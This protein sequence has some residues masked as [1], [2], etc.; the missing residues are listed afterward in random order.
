[1]IMKSIKGFFSTLVQVGLIFSFCVALLV[2]ALT[3]AQSYEAEVFPV[4]EGFQVY[5]SD[6]N[7]TTGN[8]II[9]GAMKKVRKCEFLELSVFAK[10]DDERVMT[11]LKVEFLDVGA[12]SR[13][14]IYQSFGPWIIDAAGFDYDGVRLEFYTRHRCHALWETES[15]LYTEYT[16]WEH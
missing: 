3:I 15:H 5:S 2:G 8:V 13:P 16:K 10:F 1:M 4:V 7:P 14:A 11:P 9:Y 6:V 12:K